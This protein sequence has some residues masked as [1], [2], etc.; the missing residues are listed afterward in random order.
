[1]SRVSIESS[2]SSQSSPSPPS[3]R[4]QNNDYFKPVPSTFNYTLRSIQS[5]S[6][7]N[8]DESKRRA[9]IRLALERKL[10]S[11]HLRVLLSNRELVEKLYKKY[12]FLREEDAKEQ[13]LTHL[14]TLNAVDIHCFTTSF[15]DTIL[16]YTLVIESSSA[17]TG[18]ISIGGTL[19]QSDDIPVINV[20]SH[21]TIRHVNLGLL[22]TLTIFVDP[23]ITSKLYIGNCFVRNEITGHIVRF[24]FNLTSVVQSNFTIYF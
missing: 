24:V 8:T 19:R 16:T 4:R 22:S 23:K 13:F 15:V 6:D 20:N 21:T 12:A 18:T 2:S 17:L 5:L 3:K 1:M 10:L 14:L 9:F 11:K 7:V